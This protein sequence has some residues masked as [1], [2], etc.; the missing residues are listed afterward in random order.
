MIDEG[1]MYENVYIITVNNLLILLYNTNVLDQI[2]NSSAPILIAFLP[3]FELIDPLAFHSK[4]VPN[5]RSSFLLA[6]HPEMTGRRF[7]VAGR[8]I[9]LV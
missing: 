5:S 1:R 7:H 2:A 6:V 9:K 8:Q 3:N 4:F